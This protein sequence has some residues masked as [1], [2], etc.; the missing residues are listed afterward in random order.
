MLYMDRVFLDKGGSS[1]AFPYRNI[2]AQ[3]VYAEV[4]KM[5]FEDLT[6]RKFNKLY[7]K[8]RAPDY[9][10]PKG[11]KVVMWECCCDCGKTI[12]VASFKLKSGDTKSCGCFSRSMATTH[13]LHDTRLYKIW[14]NMKS[15]CYNTSVIEYNDY[16]GRGITVCDEWLHDFQAFYDWAMS[17]GYRDDLTIDRIDVNGNYE[18]SNCRW[19]SMKVQSNNTRKNHVLTYNGEA[20]TVSEWAEIL[21]INKHTLSNRILRGWTVE[22]ALTEVVHSKQNSGY[23]KK[24]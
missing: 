12:T 10:S 9:V 20:H 22:R 17:N 1:T 8:N 16:G 3:S 19:V 11:K 21:H 4:N 6:G 15:R 2:K 23:V 13:G 14:C 5:R 24:G 18:P 7:V